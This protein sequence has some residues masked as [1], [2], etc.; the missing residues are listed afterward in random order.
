MA[1]F[2]SKYTGE[3]FLDKNK[4]KNTFDDLFLFTV[5]QAVMA[6]AIA[7]PFFLVDYTSLPLSV[8]VLT[9]TMWLPFSWIIKHWIGIGHAIVRTICIVVLWYVFPNLRFVAIPLAIVVVYVATLI[10]LHKRY[11]NSV[12][13]NGLD[14]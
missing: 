3:N 2:I 10:V 9:G 7:I 11:K 1:M 4:T 14:Q 5:A 8:G 12:M 13:S 6:Y